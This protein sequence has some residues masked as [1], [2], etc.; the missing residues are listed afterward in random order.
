MKAAPKA[1]EWTSALF[2]GIAA[3]A[4]LCIVV[5]MNLR[6]ASRNLGLGLD[7]LQLY[8]QMLSVWMVF[9]VA[10]VLGWENS[11]IE[12]DYLAERL[13]ERVQP[14]HNIA[15]GLVSLSMCVLLVV[16]GVLA[17]QEYWMGTSPSVNI[18][19]PLYYVPVVIGVGTLG[20]VYVHAIAEAVRTIVARWTET[21][22]PSAREESG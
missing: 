12:I 10:G 5:L 13:P 17:M 16:G 22:A 4:L 3:I 1:T 9:I 14:Y 15:V 2:Y 8:A 18:P 19:L 6:I 11:H 20:L 7:G 21:D